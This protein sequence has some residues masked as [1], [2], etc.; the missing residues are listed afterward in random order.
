MVSVVD[1]HSAFRGS[2]LGSEN[3]KLA[4]KIT[5]GAQNE[6]IELM[7]SHT[8]KFRQKLSLSF[9]EGK[10]SGMQQTCLLLAPKYEELASLLA[11]QKESN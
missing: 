8:I 4:K 7:A 1:S 5:K 3:P 6:F 10:V 2:R 9:K 11:I